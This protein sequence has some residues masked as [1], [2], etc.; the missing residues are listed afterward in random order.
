[1]AG[2][3]SRIFTTTRSVITL[4]RKS[5]DTRPAEVC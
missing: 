2:G 3:D 1:M 5:V 4:L